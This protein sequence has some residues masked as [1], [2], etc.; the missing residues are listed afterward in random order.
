MSNDPNTFNTM[1]IR[2]WDKPQLQNAKEIPIPPHALGFPQGLNWLDIDKS[3]NIRI[4]GFSDNVTDTTVKLHLDAWSDTTLYSAGSTWLEVAQ[5]DRDF[6]HGTFATTDDHPWDKP[7]A[8]TSRVI[9]FAK[10]Y[11]EPP[12][13][14]VWLNALDMDK[15][16]NWRVKAFADNITKTEF[17]L[18]L[19]TWG[20]TVLYLASATWIAH[21]ANRTNIASGAY[22]ITDVRP[23]EKPQVTNTGNASFGK[24]FQKA[25]LL[26]VAFNGF[27][28][29]HKANLRLRAL[30]SNLT[31]T[32]FTWNLDAWGDT[33]LYSAG[34]S[35]LAVQDF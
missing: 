34:A 15:T 16:H 3:G 14:V 32:G 13:V 6:Q 1:Q 27:D 8:L 24:T 35:Y 17:T 12:K 25:P 4:K 11:A 33:V 23:W 18:H 28:I 19:D 2:A 26:L 5:N 9:K 31:T 30:K 20:D 29:D 21:P 22:N 7:Q 10:P